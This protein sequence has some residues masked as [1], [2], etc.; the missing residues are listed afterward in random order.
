MKEELPDIDFCLEYEPPPE[1]PL[2]TPLKAPPSRVCC[3][4]GEKHSLG[5][6]N[7]N[8]FMFPACRNCREGK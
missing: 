1:T 7:K 6:F 5:M 4:C 2:G 8:G 3:E